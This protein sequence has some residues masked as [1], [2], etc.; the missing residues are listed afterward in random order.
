MERGEIVYGIQESST[1]E[2]IINEEIWFL[3][4]DQEISGVLLNTIAID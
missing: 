3:Y 1:I 4:D 2:N